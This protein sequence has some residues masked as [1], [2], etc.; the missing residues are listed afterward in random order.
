MTTEA[1]Q[2][3]L[4]DHAEQPIQIGGQEIAMSYA[5][6]MDEDVPKRELRITGFGQ[7]RE[8]L[9]AYLDQDKQH[10]ER[11]SLSRTV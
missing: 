8:A 3:I 5:K 9:E 6:S 1:A 10:I 2:R 11:L 4:A 7:S